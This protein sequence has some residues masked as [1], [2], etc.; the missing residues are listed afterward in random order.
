VDVYSWQVWTLLAIVSCDDDT[1]RLDAS[2][3]LQHG[4]AFAGAAGALALARYFY[5]CVRPFVTATGSGLHRW[6]RCLL[7]LLGVRE[8]GEG[9]GGG[10]GARSAADV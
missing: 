10:R 9:E 6:A 7:M 8:S 2:S 5:V 4:V 3:G 1:Y